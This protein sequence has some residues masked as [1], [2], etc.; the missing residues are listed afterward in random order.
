M[1][2]SAGVCYLNSDKV[3]PQACATKCVRLA[4]QW[5]KTLSQMIVFFFLNGEIS[6]VDFCDSSRY[7]ISF[8]CVLN[9][10]GQSIVCSLL[11]WS[12]FSTVWTMSFCFP[13]ARLSHTK[14]FGSIPWQPNPVWHSS[15]YLYRDKINSW[16]RRLNPISR[17]WSDKLTVLIT[18]RYQTKLLWRKTSFCFL[19]ENFIPPKQQN[20]I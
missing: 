16:E 19:L 10:R 3:S 17:E 6:A 9:L 5:Q 20:T 2:V 7:E 14:L 18:Q 1:L 11:F 4:Q 13:W 8:L 15:H 12:L